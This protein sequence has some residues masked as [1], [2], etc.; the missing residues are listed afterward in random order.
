MAGGLGRIGV[1]QGEERGSQ[2]EEGSTAQVKTLP[3]H[4]LGM[5]SQVESTL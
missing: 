2:G 1:R 3:Y 5:K 4:E